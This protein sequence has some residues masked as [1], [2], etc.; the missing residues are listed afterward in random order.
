MKNTHTDA[1]QSAS[2]NEKVWQQL[3]KGAIVAIIL[4]VIIFT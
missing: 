1:T 4:Y 3:L 2:G